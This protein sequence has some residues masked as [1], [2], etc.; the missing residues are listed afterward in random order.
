MSAGGMASGGVPGGGPSSGSGRSSGPGGVGGAHGPNPL[1]RLARAL[2]NRY[3]TAPNE[4]DLEQIC[5]IILD[6]EAIRQTAP[7]TPDDW[8]DAVARHCPSAGRHRFAIDNS[9]LDAL[10]EEIRRQLRQ[11]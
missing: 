7:P 10:L 5:R 3:G 4:P 9:D 2:R 6:I 11:P 8:R 1:Y